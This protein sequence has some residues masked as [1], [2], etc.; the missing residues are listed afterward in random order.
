MGR[1]F[2]VVVQSLDSDSTCGALYHSIHKDSG[3]EE[4]RTHFPKS[5]KFERPIGKGKDDQVAPIA[6][7]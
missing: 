3:R 6:F 5:K 2:I 7:M 4:C 1:T